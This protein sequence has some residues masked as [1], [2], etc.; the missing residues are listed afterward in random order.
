MSLI[1]TSH[2]LV[3]TPSETTDLRLGQIVQLKAPTEINAQA[4]CLLGYPDDTGILLNGGRGGAK[5]APDTIR[6]VLFKMTPD[7]FQNENPVVFD[8]GNIQIESSLEK[9]HDSAFQHAKQILSLTRLIS[10]GGGHD[11]GFADTAAFLETHENTERPLILNFDAHLD[12]RTMEKGFHSGTPFRRLLQKY[13]GRFDFYEIGIQPQCNSREHLKW[14]EDQGAKVISIDE[15]QRQGLLATLIATLT[16][17]LK[18]PLWISLDMDALTS[19][20]APGCSQSWT[21]GLQTEDFLPALEWLC[22]SFSCK[23]LGIYEVSPALDL[24]NQTSKLAALIIHRFLTWTQ[25]M[26]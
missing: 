8:A 16:P 5:D 23:G 11:F 14:A 4:V 20:E 26:A 19:T 3:F 13:P 6:K 24:D 25:G 9:T 18:R 12:V 1:S 2:K 15:C 10:L 7:V 22:Q 17:N 21:T